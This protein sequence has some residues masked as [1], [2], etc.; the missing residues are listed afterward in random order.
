MLHWKPSSG[1]DGR[2]WELFNDETPEG[3]VIKFSH[4]TSYSWESFSED[5]CSGESVSMHEAAK[6]L[7]K[8]YVC[9]VKA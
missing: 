2:R 5:G 8:D 6:A 4:R 3:R 7:I 1:Y 9:N